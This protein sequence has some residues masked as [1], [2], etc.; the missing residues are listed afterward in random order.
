MVSEMFSSPV[1][2]MAMMS[3]ASAVVLS[4]RS[5][6]VAQHFTHFTVASFTFAVDDGDLLVRL[7]FTAL[8]AADAD[9]ARVV[10]VVQLGDLH[11]EW[12]FQLNLRRRHVV[13][14][15]L[16]ERVMSSAMSVWSTPAMPFSAE[17]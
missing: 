7:H 12:R 14:D 2:V 17:A 4:I 9:N 8:D 11:L 13:D 16:I 3:P 15:R 5:R 6:P 1:P 10:V